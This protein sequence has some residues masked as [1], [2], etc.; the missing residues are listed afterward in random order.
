MLVSLQYPKKNMIKQQDSSPFK[1]AGK[2]LKRITFCMHGYYTCVYHE[3]TICKNRSLLLYLYADF[4]IE[5]VSAT[6]MQSNLVR[7]FT[8]KSSHLTEYCYMRFNNYYVEHIRGDM[9]WG[10]G[11][12]T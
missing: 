4:V 2:S 1:T 10:A 12:I 3:G 7:L 11:V 5:W 6:V 9:R 8:D